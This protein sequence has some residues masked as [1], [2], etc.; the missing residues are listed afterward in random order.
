MIDV[1]PSRR[2][3][4]LDDWFAKIPDA[5]RLSVEYVNMNMHR[6]YRDVFRKLCQKATIAIDPFH[7]VRY[8]VDT[9]ESARIATM[10]RFLE[11][12]PEYRLLKKY[13]RLLLAKS[14]LDSFTRPIGV[15]ALGREMYTLRHSGRD[16]FPRRIC[17]TILEIFG[18]IKGR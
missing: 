6:P 8:V 12:D 1:L 7:Y 10:G 18:A 15:A 14:S 3:P 5:E 2:K 4:W 16:A 17:Y 13:R 11:A 9:I